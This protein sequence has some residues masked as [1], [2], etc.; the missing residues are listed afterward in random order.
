M[1]VTVLVRTSVEAC[2]VMGRLVAAVISSIAIHGE[3]SV[4]GSTRGQG[5]ARCTAA[6]SEAFLEE[7]AFELNLKGHFQFLA[8]GILVAVKGWRQTDMQGPT[9][10]V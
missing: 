1:S 9:S 4:P 6:V 2:S 5:R 8:R 10:R 3:P 7:A